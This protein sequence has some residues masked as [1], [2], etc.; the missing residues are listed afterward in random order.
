MLLGKGGAFDQPSHPVE[1]RRGMRAPTDAGEPNSVPLVAARRTGAW[2]PGGSS[3]PSAPGL[4]HRREAGW[5][6]TSERPERPRGPS[7][8]PTPR[9]PELPCI[10]TRGFGTGEVRVCPLTMSTSG[11]TPPVP[12]DPLNRHPP[13]QNNIRWSPAPRFPP[14][15]ASLYGAVLP[16]R[17]PRARR[18]LP[19]D[20]IPASGKARTGHPRPGPVSALGGFRGIQWCFPLRG[21]VLLD[22]AA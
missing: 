19:S 8:V 17:S 1:L 13:P 7:I 16:Q 2:V 10:W 11:P 20:P 3:G 4:P 9:A 15:W 22:V 21:L 14:G 12:P 6:S 5:P 18:G